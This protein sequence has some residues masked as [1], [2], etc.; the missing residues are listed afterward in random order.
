[1]SHAIPIP[2]AK[3][4]RHWP[5]RVIARAALSHRH[6]ARLPG[7]TR[8]E[9]DGVLKARNVYDYAYNVEDL[10]R[11]LREFDARRSTHRPSPPSF[12]T[13]LR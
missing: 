2:P 7:L 1:M 12:P 4:S 10:D 11:N 6:A 8:F 13:P 9:F 3:R 5:S